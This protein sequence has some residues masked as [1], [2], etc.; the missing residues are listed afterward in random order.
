M[1]FKL[2]FQKCT[3]NVHKQLEVAR[4]EIIAAQFEIQFADLAGLVLSGSDYDRKREREKERD[5]AIRKT[6]SIWRAFRDGECVRARTD[7]VRLETLSDNAFC[8][9][10]THR[11]GIFFRKR[12]SPK[13][14]S[15]KT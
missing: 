12:F 1:N 11:F 13:I 10:V 15:T 9:N 8:H 5:R 6:E 14:L 3:Q 2:Y 7:I 4:F